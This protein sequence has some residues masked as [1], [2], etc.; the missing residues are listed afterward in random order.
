M[1]ECERCGVEVDEEFE[2]PICERCFSICLS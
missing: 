1:S 2:I